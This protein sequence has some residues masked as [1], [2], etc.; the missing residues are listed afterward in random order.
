MEKENRYVKLSR[1]GRICKGVEQKG[2]LS[3]LSW[4]YCM[5]RVVEEHDDEANFYFG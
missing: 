3:Y 1:K 5:E 4:A 2:G